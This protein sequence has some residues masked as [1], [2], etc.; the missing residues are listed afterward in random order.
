[1]RREPGRSAYG[2]SIGQDARF[3]GSQDASHYDENCPPTI[4][5]FAES[6]LLDIQIL[7]FKETVQLA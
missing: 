7:D 3:P 5:D 6:L 4:S 2:F 1:M